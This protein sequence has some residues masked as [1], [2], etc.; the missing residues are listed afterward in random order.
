MVSETNRSPPREDINVFLIEMMIGLG[1][2]EAIAHHVAT[3][4]RQAKTRVRLMRV[5]FDAL[6]QSYC[7][8]DTSAVH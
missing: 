6:T 8:D 1:N 3:L 5:T 2:G 4:L 7:F